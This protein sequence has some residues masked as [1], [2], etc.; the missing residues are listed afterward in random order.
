MVPTI[1]TSTWKP[2]SY[3]PSLLKSLQT[4]NKN[5]EELQWFR[6]Q[7]PCRTPLSPSTL[8]HMAPPPHHLTSSSYWLLLC[9]YQEKQF[10]TTGGIPRERVGKYSPSG[11]PSLLRYTSHRT[12]C[13]VKKAVGCLTVS[14]LYLHFMTCSSTTAAAPHPPKTPSSPITILSCANPMSFTSKAHLS[15]I[16]TGLWLTLSGA[17]LLAPMMALTFMLWNDSLFEKSQE[18]LSRMHSLPSP[19]SQCA[20]CGSSMSCSLTSANLCTHTILSLLTYHQQGTN[21]SRSK[22]TS[23]S[24]E[25]R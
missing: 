5:V 3:T 20:R 22:E 18:F 11:T 23:S 9:P 1:V 16:L 14:A 24:R 19:V 13:L 4:T 15:E 25:L 6:P 12:A 7:A 10:I 21:T 17:L 2:N 8:A